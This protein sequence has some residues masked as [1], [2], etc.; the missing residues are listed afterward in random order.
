MLK[1]VHWGGKLSI[2]SAVDWQTHETYPTGHNISEVDWGDHDSSTNN[3]D[4][5]LLSE[6]D[7]G[8][9]HDSNFF[10]FLVN[11]DY[12]AKPKDFFTQ[13][14]LGGLHHMEG[15]LVHHLE[16]QKGPNCL[17]HQLDRK[18]DSTQSVD[19]LLSSSDPD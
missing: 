15:K 5:F 3:M 14:L 11:I 19:H 16:L 2:N 4:E 12:G 7:W 1:E 10:L 8:A 9:L 18:W 6:V 17:D 13:E